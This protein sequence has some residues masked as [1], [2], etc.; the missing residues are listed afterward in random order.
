MQSFN[1]EKSSSLEV[2]DNLAKSK[3]SAWVPMLAGFLTIAIIGISGFIVDGLT[4]FH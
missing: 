3:S 1:L 2:S 4:F